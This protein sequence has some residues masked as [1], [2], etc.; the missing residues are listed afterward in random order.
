MSPRPSAFVAILGCAALMRPPDTDRRHSGLPPCVNPDP[1]PEPPVSSGPP[2]PH[3]PCVPVPPRPKGYQWSKPQP[4][5]DAKAVQRS[6]KDKK[7]RVRLYNAAG[8]EVGRGDFHKYEHL[9]VKGAA[10]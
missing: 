4:Q 8:I 2:N 5:E 6:E 9:P 10:Q 7:F 1:Q 3:G